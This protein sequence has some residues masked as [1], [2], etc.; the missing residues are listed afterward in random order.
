MGS[1]VT[2]TIATGSASSRRATNASARADAPSNHW[3]SSSAQ[4]NG[5][6]SA[7]SD[8]RLSAASP[9]RKRSGACPPLSPN[10][11][12]SASCCGAGQALEPIEHRRAQMLKGGERELHLRL[13]ADRPQDAKVGGRADRV[14]QERRLAHAR[15][16]AEHE[17]AALAPAHRVE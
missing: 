13:D 6:S 8:S 4:S 17:S 16:A 1:R 14:V 9:T 10:A 11:T 15:L 2:N 12:R 7:T 3:A 5:R